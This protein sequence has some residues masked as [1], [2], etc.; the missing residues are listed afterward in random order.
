LKISLPFHRSTIKPLNR[1][2]VQ[3]RNTSDKRPNPIDYSCRLDFRVRL[4]FF[5]AILAELKFVVKARFFKQILTRPNRRQNLR[6]SAPI[7][8]NLRLKNLVNPV[9]LSK[10]FF[11]SLRELRGEKILSVEFFF[12]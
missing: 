12:N 1:L 6:K 11:V 2:P 9:I 8:R 4:H 10:N 7:S 3:F 5:F